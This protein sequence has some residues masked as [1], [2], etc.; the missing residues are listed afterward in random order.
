[1]TARVVRISVAPVKSLGLIHPEEVSLTGTGIVGDR[2]FWLLDENGGLYNA[3]RDGSLLRVRPEW[4]ESARQLALTFP[5]GER[6]EGTVRL[7]EP[8]DARMYDSP[9][10]SRAVVGPWQDALRRYTG[11]TLTLLWAEYGAV[12]RALINGTIS[13][14]SLASL[15]RLREE[16][17]LDAPLDGRRF[18]MTFEIDGVEAHAE[19]EWIGKTVEIGEARVSFGGE[20]GRCVVTSRNP[21]TGDVDFPTLATLAGYRRSGYKE[22]LPCGI[23]G[24]VNTP[25]RVRVGDPAFV[26]SEAVEL[27][28][29]RVSASNR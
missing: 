10:I 13:V 1:M 7:G 3:K 6:V 17:G 12:D 22:D 20:I 21:D 15:E 5:D 23:R 16:S 18:R 9:R 24:R 19:D 26:V 27:E 29:R 28:L 8:V 14:I 11:K 4:D 2:R 25:G